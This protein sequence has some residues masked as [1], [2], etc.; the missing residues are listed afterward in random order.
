MR[1][2]VLSV[3]SA[4]P[5]PQRPAGG[6][7]ERGQFHARIGA[8]RTGGEV[9]SHGRRAVLKAALGLGLWFSCLDSVPARADDAR[10][11][12]PQEGDRFVFPFG[13]REGQLV[14]LE[15]L[16]L[17]GPQQLAYPMDPGA[18]IVRSGWPAVL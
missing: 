2:S 9:M 11:A 17:G 7:A 18:K 16:P 10:T 13:D 14:T 8:A 4:A 12:R 15:D 3:V 6:C 1:V 5:S